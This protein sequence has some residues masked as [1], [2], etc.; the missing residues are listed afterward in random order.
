MGEGQAMAAGL[1]G[2]T[3]QV[4]VEGGRIISGVAAGE[5]LVEVML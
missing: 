4:R 3:I 1:E 5:R 2:R